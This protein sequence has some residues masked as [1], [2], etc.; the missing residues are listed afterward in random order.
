MGKNQEKPLGPQNIAGLK[1]DNL[2][3]LKRWVYAE[4]P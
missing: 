4:N 3:A 2:K 1:V